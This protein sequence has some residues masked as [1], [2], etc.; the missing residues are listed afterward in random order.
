MKRRIIPPDEKN[1]CLKC[2]YG[3]ISHHHKIQPDGYNY[4]YTICDCYIG[5]IGKNVGHRTQCKH[6]EEDE[7]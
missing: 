1:I 5:Y 2:K 6:F 3:I 4:A 7:Q